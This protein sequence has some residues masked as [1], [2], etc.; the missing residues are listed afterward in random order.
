[1]QTAVIIEDEKP[2]A[3][4]LQ[5]LIERQGMEVTAILHSVSDGIHWFNNHPQPGL[6]FADIRLSDGTF[7]DLSGKIPLTAP[8]IFTTAYDQ[9]AIKAFKT[10]GIDYLLKPIDENELEKAIRRY[11]QKNHPTL[12]DYSR[13]LDEIQKSKSYKTRFAI[14]SGHHWH[15]IPVEDIVCFRSEFKSTFLYH[16][17]GKSLLMEESL[18]KLESTLNPRDFFRANRQYIIHYKYIKNIV[19]YGTD[20]LKVMLKN[21][22]A[23][24]V[25]ISRERVKA[26]KKWIGE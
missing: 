21:F 9:Y 7:F 11:R 25:I 5:K 26:F 8:V 13:I 15:S 23:E 12:P 17:S 18:N 19:R 3:R 4:R 2:A 6:I 1:M 16:R 14:S 22:D 24:A 20:R 10:N